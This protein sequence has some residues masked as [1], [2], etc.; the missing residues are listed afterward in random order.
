M[1]DVR[2]CSVCGKE[3]ESDSIKLLCYD[4]RR[5][6]R[7]LFGMIRD[8][9]YD[10]PGASVNEV[11]EHL[12]V[13]SSV[14]LKYLREGRLETVG[15]IKLLNCEICGKAI[16]YG[17]KCQECQQKLN[18]SFQTASNVKSRNTQTKMYTRTKKK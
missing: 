1:S 12:G 8:F 7:H 13:T 11:V 9:L 17:T 14:V 5:V 15:D 3:F 10:N 16:S 18:H 6:D 4:C 2:T